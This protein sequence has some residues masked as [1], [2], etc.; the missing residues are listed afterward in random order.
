MRLAFTRGSADGGE[1]K[2]RAWKSTR[3]LHIENPVATL[4]DVHVTFRAVDGSPIGARIFDDA[5]DWQ[6][7]EPVG[8]LADSKPREL[9]FRSG[10]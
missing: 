4:S 3:R 2:P 9:R 1:K 8:Q 10:I 7:V 5:N 6:Y